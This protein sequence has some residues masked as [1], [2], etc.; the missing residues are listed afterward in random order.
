MGPMAVGT[1]VACPAGG[2]DDHKGDP[3]AAAI[4]FDYVLDTQAREH[5]IAAQLG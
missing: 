2:L 5:T 4:G 1:E 3:F